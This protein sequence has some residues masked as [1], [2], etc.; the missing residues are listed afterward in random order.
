MLEKR[1]FQR[2]EKSSEAT[3][4]AS[5]GQLVGTVTE[6]SENGFSFISNEYLDLKDTKCVEL[7]LKIKTTPVRVLAQPKWAEQIAGKYRYGFSYISDKDKGVE[8]KNQIREANE[9]QGSGYFLFEVTVYL[10]DVNVFGT[11]YFS[12]YF[13]WQGMAREEYFMTVKGYEQI[14]AAGVRM[15]TKK[16]WVDYKNH[17]TVFDHIIMRIQ[18]K[19]IKRCSFEMIFTYFHKDT[20]K[21]IASGGQILAFSDHTGKLIPI[22][23]QILDVI[24]KHKSL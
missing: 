2:L 3:L 13:D 1:L 18:S 22:P 20:G 15:I 24:L 7:L 14:M 6:L 21:L 9:E 10:K 23:K 11:G 8:F 4:I 19:N 16:A 12:R 17:S 5:E